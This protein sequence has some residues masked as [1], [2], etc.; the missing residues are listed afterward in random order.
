MGDA[1]LQEIKPAATLTTGAHTLAVI[2]HA[3]QQTC[4]FEQTTVADH[5]HNELVLTKKR[6][7]RHF[8]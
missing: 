5:W 1:L 6:A 3:S 2:G 4:N 7:L 8:Y